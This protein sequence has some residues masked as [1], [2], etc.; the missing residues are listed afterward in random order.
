[1]VTIDKELTFRDRFSSYSIEK[2]EDIFFR[3]V[4][5][6]QCCYTNKAYGTKW[7]ELYKQYKTDAATLLNRRDVSAYEKNIIFT[8]LKAN[9]VSLFDQ[10]AKA[11]FQCRLDRLKLCTF[12]ES[13]DQEYITNALRNKCRRELAT[14]IYKVV[15][16]N[17]QK[18]GQ[19][20]QVQYAPR[21]SFCWEVCGEELHANKGENVLI[22]ARDINDKNISRGHGAT[23]ETLVTSEMF[24]F[25]S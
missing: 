20:D 22:R 1:M 10:D 17:A 5:N 3:E 6:F 9:Y 13:P 25:L 2:A 18:G 19:T 16:S 8:A 11:L 23:M 4:N 15:Y 7:T 12:E 14:L 24:I 21:L